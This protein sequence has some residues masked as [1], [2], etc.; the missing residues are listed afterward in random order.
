MTFDELV[1]YLKLGGVTLWVI[2]LFSLFA[3]G[4]AIER[5]ITLWRFSERTRV[6]GETIARHL[7]RGDVGAARSAAE[8]ST[9]LSAELFRVGFA[10]HEQAKDRPAIVH[11]AV[12]RER[13]QLGLRLKQNLWVLG[14]IGATAPFIGLLGTVVGIMRAFRDLGIDVEAGGSGGSAAVMTGISE[15]LI[16]TAV[17]ILVAVEAVLLYNYFQARVSRL[18]IELRLLADEFVE[19]LRGPEHHGVPPPPASEP[20][21]AAGGH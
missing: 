20:A 1:H 11:A 12:E 17:G 7:L 3:L 13:A 19:L 9:I 4:V 15:A 18:V 16:V 21:P 6:L 2:L 14:T 10:R 8:R 5:W